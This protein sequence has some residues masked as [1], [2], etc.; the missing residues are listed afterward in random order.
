M[1]ATKKQHGSLY[2]RARPRT[3]SEIA[4]LSD[5]V[6]RLE[7]LNDILSFQGQVFWLSG[8]TGCGKTSIARIIARMVS[9]PCCIFEIDAQDAT[10]E[11]LREW[12]EKCQYTCMFGGG[13]T[14]IINEAHGLHTKA[15]SR[16]Q[17]L[18][19]DE[20]VQKNGTFL[21][22][23]TDKGQQHLFDNKFDAF[24]FLSR[25]LCFSITLTED[26]YLAMAQRISW[27][28]QEYGFGELPM[29]RSYELIRNLKGNVRA[30]LQAVASRQV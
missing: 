30:A 28:S 29:T 16:L 7:E 25:A 14:F 17:T 4:G 22:T 6:R 3:L 5:T 24:P 12:E 1:I 26:D 20:N 2:E 11:L 19:E 18:L 21:F 27:V 15:V 23:T 13:W 10:M 8:P 9:D